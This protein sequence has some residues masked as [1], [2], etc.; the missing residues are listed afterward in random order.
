MK[1]KRCLAFGL[2]LYV[3]SIVF[4]PQFNVQSDETLPNP[5]PIKSSSLIRWS[6]DGQ[7]IM[8]FRDT[9][10]VIGV[11]DVITQKS[12]APSGKRL[13][14]EAGL[15]GIGIFKTEL[16]PDELSPY[17]FI[18]PNRRYV[19]YPG[20]K[21]NF[22]SDENGVKGEGKA[23]HL[24]LGDREQQSFVDTKA[25]IGDPFSEYFQI[26]WSGNSQA[27]VLTGVSAFGDVFPFGDGYFDNYAGSLREIRKLN[28]DQP[29]FSGQKYSST[30]VYRLAYSGEAI[31]MAASDKS[32]QVIL[33]YNISQP[34]KSIEIPYEAFGEF[35]DASFAYQ[36]ESNV[37]VFN[38]QGI[39]SYNTATKTTRL[40]SSVANSKMIS[41]A[42]FSPDGARIAL[43]M[44]SGGIYLLNITLTIEK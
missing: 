24:M 1:A 8:T 34:D 25:T 26:T 21:V 23:W 9:G 6:D 12:I 37:L 14:R 30:K 44:R 16:A 3:A 10:E 35:V 17:I 19:V 2:F 20:N 15:S 43:K 4:L 36:D 27:F 28:I 7:Y 38:Q 22:P 31:L 11:Y 18:S 5:L 29:G 42:V 33:I 41:S 39:V 32:H 13:Q 40:L